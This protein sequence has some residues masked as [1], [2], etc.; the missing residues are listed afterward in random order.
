[1]LVGVEHALLGALGHQQA[2]LFL[3]DH[4]AALAID[5]QQAQQQVARCVQQPHERR[6]QPRQQQHRDRHVRG[7]LFRRRQ[8]QPLGHQLA[9]HDLDERDQHETQHDA[10]AARVRQQPRQIFGVQP[11]GDMAAQRIA[12]H[13][14]GDQHDQGDADL[15]AGQEVLRRLGVAQGG[16][17][18][19]AVAR[20]LLEAALARSH[21]RHLRQREEAVAQGQ[22]EDEREFGQHRGDDGAGCMGTV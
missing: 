19:A 11:L 14:A 15:H 6:G 7:D 5:P 9:D 20:H 4:A 12:R 3:G 1:V 16:G 2:D 21:Q 22:H 8:R 13:R 17:G 10:E 18:L